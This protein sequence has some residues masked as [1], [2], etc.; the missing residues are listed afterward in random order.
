[1]K[2][3]DPKSYFEREYS[4]I[5]Y[6]SLMSISI[7]TFVSFPLAVKI[8]STECTCVSDIKYLVYFSVFVFKLRQLLTE[9]SDLSEDEDDNESNSSQDQQ[10]PEG[11]D[12]GTNTPRGRVKH[13]PAEE[14]A[15]PSGSLNHV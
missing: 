4:K 14:E 1:M 6:S 2:P 12:L 8:T 5:K 9:F 13:H 15:T 10:D 3:T 7:C 11:T